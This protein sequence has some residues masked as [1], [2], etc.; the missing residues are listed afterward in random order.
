MRH[1]IMPSRTCSSSQRQSLAFGWYKTLFSLREIY[2]YGK[3]LYS[4]L[5]VSE[6]MQ[7]RGQT[8]NFFFAYFPWDQEV[9]ATALATQNLLKRVIQS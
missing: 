9:L 6:L 7:S 5:A 8:Q 2:C 3:A 4:I 1:H